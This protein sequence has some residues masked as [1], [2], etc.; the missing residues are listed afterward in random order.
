M[1][2]AD[3]I[4]RVVAWLRREAKRVGEETVFRI[5]NTPF[6][7]PEVGTIMVALNAAATALA[8]HE[9]RSEADG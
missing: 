1:T 8:C 2:R 9:H 7:I 3:L 5:G 4:A 6:S